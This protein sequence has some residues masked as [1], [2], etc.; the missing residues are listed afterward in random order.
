[1]TDAIPARTLI[2]C[3]GCSNTWTAGGAAHCG[4][5][6]RTFSTPSRFDMHRSARGERGTCLDPAEVV[7]ASGER[8]LFLR[9]GI[10]RGPELTEEQKLTRFGEQ[11]AS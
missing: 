11:R 9:G 2:S 10:W 1:M 7:S 6:H 3:S 5:C 4:G 8:Q